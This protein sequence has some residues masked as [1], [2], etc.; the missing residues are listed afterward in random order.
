MPVR[1]EKWSVSGEIKYRVIGIQWGGNQSVQRLEI[2]F[3]PEEDYVPVDR[4]SQNKNDPWTL[5]TH[6][7]NPAASGS[8][9]I[10]LRVAEPKLRTRRLDMGFYVREVEISEI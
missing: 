5:W 3:N 10:R 7:W 4:L 9:L 2:R 1:V 6:V 8:Y